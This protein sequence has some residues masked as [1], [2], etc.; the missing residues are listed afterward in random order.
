MEDLQKILALSSSRHSHLC[1]RQV[2]G[3]RMA[4]LAGKIFEMSL[5]REDKALWVIS[6]TDGCFLDGIEVAAGISPGHRTLRVEDYGKIA[7]T[8]IDFKKK[9][10]V[11]IAP[12]FNIRQAAFRY[13]PGEERHYFAQLQ[14]YQIMPDEELFTVEP[15]ILTPSIDAIASQAGIRTTCTDCGEEII[16]ERE[17]IV[18]G[19][20]YCR[21]CVGQAYY[22]RQ[23][24]EQRAFA[25]QS[26]PFPDP[27]KN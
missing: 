22:I 8:F 24:E 16:N 11:R 13:A 2:L 26:A 20:P 21:G 10:A 17:I 4:M 7:A 9:E 25:L 19:E 15:V 6:E 1:P 14:G 3:V 23:A 5:P 18:D 27:I 12:R